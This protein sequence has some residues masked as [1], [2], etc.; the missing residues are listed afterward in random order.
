MHEAWVSYACVNCSK[1]NFVRIGNTLLSPTEAY[2]DQAWKCD[3]CGFVH[4]KSSPLPQQDPEGHSTSFAAWDSQLT[5]ADSLGAQRFWKAFFTTATENKDAYWK[6]CNT[7]GR[8]LPSR[9]FS[10][11]T[12]W[13]PLEKQMEC[14]GCK[15]VINASLN[16]KR[17]K[18]QLHESAARRRTAE[19]LL[20]G[21]NERLDLKALFERFE[22]KC[23]KTGKPLKFE[24]RKSWAVDHL[25]PS[26]WLYPLS[27]RNAV[28]LSKEAND[29]KRDSWP[30]QFYTN[31]EL[32]QLAK[33]LG[34]DLFLLASPEPI[35]NQNI[36]VDA[37]VTRMLTVRRATDITK[38][39]KD[40][41]KLLEDYKLV[42]KLS[43]ENKRL[44]GYIK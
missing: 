37:C 38:R 4:S 13:G 21:T 30:S 23:F 19:L 18:E 31:E 40:L 42:E 27:V 15:A 22:G 41:K 32:K 26:R 24:E 6:Q 36:D 9:A 3:H 35:I 29:N 34:A 7:C 12:G 44:L 20:A 5:S 25:L 28:L 39:I 43:D 8:I 1:H 2:D 14:R 11:H 17:T 33:I 16:P 10:G